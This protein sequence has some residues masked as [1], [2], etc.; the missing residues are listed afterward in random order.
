LTRLRRLKRFLKKWRQRCDIPSPRAEGNEDRQE[1]GDFR[2]GG[3]SHRTLSMS[4][5]AN[6]RSSRGCQ[7]SEIREQKTSIAKI[8]L[9]IQRKSTTIWL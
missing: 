6:S 1:Q 3:R 2:F 8:A 5:S 4:A 7:G 9:D